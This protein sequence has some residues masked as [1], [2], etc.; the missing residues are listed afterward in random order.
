VN[1]EHGGERVDRG[2]WPRLAAYLERVHSRP[3]FKA[4]I[5]EEKAVL[6]RL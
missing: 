3:S 2:R 5:E 1:L 6:A 4:C